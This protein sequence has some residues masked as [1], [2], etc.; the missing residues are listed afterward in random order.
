MLVYVLVNVIYVL[1]YGE[2]L[3]PILDSNEPL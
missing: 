1:S 2:V 3:G